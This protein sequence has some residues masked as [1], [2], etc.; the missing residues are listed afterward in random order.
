M[1]TE[2]QLCESFFSQLG[3]LERNQAGKRNRIPERQGKKGK[4]EENKSEFKTI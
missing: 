1:I 2:T 3:D 4:G